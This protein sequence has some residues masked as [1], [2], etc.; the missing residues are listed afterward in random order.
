MSIIYSCDSSDN[1]Q[2]GGGNS[3][4]IFASYSMLITK[5]SLEAECAVGPSV[6]HQ[7]ICGVDDFFHIVSNLELNR[8]TGRIKSIL[9]QA[10]V[11]EDFLATFI[12][13][14]LVVKEGMFVL[15]HG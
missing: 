4:I 14:H 2:G 3:N 6:V 7:I 15:D 10:K 5:F 13:F 1:V 9:S 8:N 11:D 12:F